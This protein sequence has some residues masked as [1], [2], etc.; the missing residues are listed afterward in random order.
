MTRK[1]VKV[2]GTQVKELLAKAVGGIYLTKNICYNAMTDLF[3]DSVNSLSCSHVSFVPLS[4]T[5]KQIV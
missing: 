3:P 5:L 2:T 1:A 4:A